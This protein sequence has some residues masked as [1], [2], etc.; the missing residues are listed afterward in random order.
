MI[1]F[2]LCLGN[3]VMCYGFLILAQMVIAHSSI[4]Y[5]IT[6]QSMGVMKLTVIA[7]NALALD[8]RRL[9][10]VMPRLIQNG[11]GKVVQRPLVVRHVHVAPSPHEVCLCELYTLR[12][13]VTFALT[14]ELHTRIREVVECLLYDL[15]HIFRLLRLSSLL[16]VQLLYFIRSTPVMLNCSLSVNNPQF[17]TSFR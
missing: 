4:H 6:S 7:G 11:C 5:T 1:L 13:F 9:L 14:C 15:F 16:I 10:A 17:S 2:V 12:Y 3:I 8:L